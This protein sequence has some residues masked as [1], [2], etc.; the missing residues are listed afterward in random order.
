MQEVSSLAWHQ[1]KRS[2]H[3][4]WRVAARVR[5]SSA[6]RIAYRTFTCC[7]R[8]AKLFARAPLWRTAA[9]HLRVAPLLPW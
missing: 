1:I 8:R 5:N 7:A 2:E 9:R 3:L 4:K 6:L